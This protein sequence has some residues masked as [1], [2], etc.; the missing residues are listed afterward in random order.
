MMHGS[1]TFADHFIA[2]DKLFF[3]KDKS[4]TGH[5]S[6]PLPVGF[7]RYRHLHTSGT[8]KTIGNQPVSPPVTAVT[9]G[10]AIFE[11]GADKGKPLLGPPEWHAILA[12]LKASTSPDWMPANR[13][14]EIVADADCFLRD[15]GETAHRLGWTTLDL[16][17]VHPI[18]PACR[19]DVMGLIPLLAGHQ[20]VALTDSTAI[21]R[22]A[23]ST[24]TYRQPDQLG[25]VCILQALSECPES[26]KGTEFGS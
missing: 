22:R 26:K 18:A 19:F 14:K 23:F 15:W 7:D 17:G 8:A 5:S 2:F 4:G 12:E 3:H 6:G 20:V 9:S 21:I 24:L 11:K 10:T 13:L 1:T 25:A 16:F